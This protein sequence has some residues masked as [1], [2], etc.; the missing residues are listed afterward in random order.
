MVSHNQPLQERRVCVCVAHQW[1]LSHELT[2]FRTASTVLQVTRFDKMKRTRE[3]GRV[4][5][6]KRAQRQSSLITDSPFKSD[7]LATF[8]FGF[9]GLHSSYFVAV[10]AAD[11]LVGCHFFYFD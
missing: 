4:F 10:R 5:T 2:S 7:W 1:P 3:R 9:F 6:Q 11:V 8:L